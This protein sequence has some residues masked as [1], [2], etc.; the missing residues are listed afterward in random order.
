MAEKQKIYDELQQILR[1]C[2]KQIMRAQKRLAELAGEA[3]APAPAEAVAVHFRAER[4]PNKEEIIEGVFDGKDMLG[5]EG[6]PYQVPE[7]YASKSKLVAGDVLKLTVTPE[8]RF[9]YKQIGPVERESARGVVRYH[10]EEDRYTV[11]AEGR[12]YAVLKASVTYFKG[13]T[14]DEAVILVP[15]GRGSNWA[16]LEAIIKQGNTE[17]NRQPPPPSVPADGLEE[18]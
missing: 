12:E 1:E 3:D 13:E 14:G 11:F 10:D 17:G 15:H 9:I 7:N 6:T 2:Q 18:I 4:Y 8:G 16:A 5:T